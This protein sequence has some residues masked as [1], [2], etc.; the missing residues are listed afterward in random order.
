[1]DSRAFG[2]S[3]LRKEDPRL[4][5]GRGKYAADFRLSGLVQAA[6]R[7]RNLPRGVAPAKPVLGES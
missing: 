2:R 6:V 1:M 5:T 4:L 7:L 3:I